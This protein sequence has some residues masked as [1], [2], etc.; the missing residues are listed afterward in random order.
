[1]KNRM[2][3]SKGSATT[4]QTVSVLLIII[5]VLIS[6][7]SLSYT[8]G[9]RDR[10]DKVEELSNTISGTLGQLG[11][12]VESMRTAIEE[13]KEIPSPSPTPSPSP[14]PSP[15]PPPEKV[16]L[17]IG[18]EFAPRSLDPPDYG[19]DFLNGVDQHVHEPLFIMWWEDD[20]VVYKPVL[21]ESYEQVDD[22][23]WVFKIKKGIKFSD[24][25]D[26]DAWDVWWSL[27]R[28]DPRPSNMVWSL[29]ARIESYEVLDDY[30]IKMVTIYAMPNLQAWLC[31]GWTNIISYDWVKETGQEHVEPL[32]GI[33]PGTG[34]Y[35]WTKFEPM[36][37]AKMTLNPYWRGETPKITDI[38]IYAALDNT[39]RVMA[40]EAGSFDLICP[41]PEE[42]LE[43]LESKGFKLWVTPAP[44]VSQIQINNQ[45]P[46]CDD[47]RVRQAMAY[48]IDYEE[49][50]SSIY[51]RYAIRPRSPAPTNTIGYKDIVMYDYDPEKARQLLA[52]A[53]YPDGIKIK[54]TVVPG[55]S[56]YKA[57]E[58]A[59]AVQAYFKDVGIELDVEVMERSAYRSVTR[60]IRQDYLAGEE[61][62]FVDHC[63]FRSWHADTLYSGDDLFSLYHSTQGTNRWYV[64]I[65]E[66]DELFEFAISLEPL[67]ERIEACED[68]Q[69]LW[70]EN[71]VGVP[72][73]SAPYIYTTV[74]EFE[75]LITEPNVYPWFLEG[76]FS[77]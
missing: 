47:I 27:S 37:Y 6:G 51:G 17:R 40:L 1:M 67:D 74:P 29:D 18:Y 59:G 7:I 14:S 30:T 15:S 44:L 16:V 77:K 57:L 54:M 62:E 4:V 19:D 28:T 45:Y 12:T 69:Q 42:A 25:S 2:N 73:Y 41:T 76:Y 68:A 11:T 39:A 3:M 50:L 52:D 53:G 66:L 75:G 22:L 34:P 38:E 55:W 64:E 32:A 8:M 5:A 49:L 20:E 46:P 21:V 10:I 36:V 61:V 72:L 60:D 43:D 71:C 9:L 70:M 33:P 58:C 24:G 31:Q 26:L 63:S 35:M 56:I 65:P 13:L 48:A 23:T